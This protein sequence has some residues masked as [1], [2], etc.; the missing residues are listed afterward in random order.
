M[1]KKNRV[2]GYLIL[3]ILFCLVSVIS[4]AVPTQKTASFWVAY[5]FTIVAFAAQLGI[6]KAAFGKEDALKSSFLGFPVIHIGIVYAVIQVV[7]FS[8][9]LF[10]PTLPTWSAVIICTFIVGISAICIITANIGRHEIER[11]GTTVKKKV[12]YLKSLHADV[13]LLA[14]KETDTEIKSALIQLAEKIRFSDPMSHEQ[15][16]DLDQQLVAKV[17][18]L[19]TA[20]NKGEII[21]EILLLLDERNKK[22]RILK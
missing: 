19:K 17:S 2:K 11:V 9:F 21:A 10:V 1:M 8:I 20:T 16:A 12:F 7:A 13:E 22:C 5:A 3:G 4:F 18:E 15:L 6:W 14:N